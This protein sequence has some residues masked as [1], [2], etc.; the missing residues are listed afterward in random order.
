MDSSGN[1]TTDLL[2]NSILY[3]IVNIVMLFKA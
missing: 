3:M 2:E 1:I